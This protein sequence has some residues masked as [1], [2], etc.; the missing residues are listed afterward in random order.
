MKEVT[1]Y[2]IFEVKKLLVM[3]GYQTTFSVVIPTI[4][5]VVLMLLKTKRIKFLTD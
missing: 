5:H 1:Y 2:G 4:Y 3:T